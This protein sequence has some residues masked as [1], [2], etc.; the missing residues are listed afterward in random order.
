[1]TTPAPRL[2]LAI[3]P[4]ELAVLYDAPTLARLGRWPRSWSSDAWLLSPLLVQL[5]IGWLVQQQ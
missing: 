3:T 4:S 2:Y 1:M 5:R